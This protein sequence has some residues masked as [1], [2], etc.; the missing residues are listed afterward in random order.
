[1]Y[2]SVKMRTYRWECVATFNEKDYVQADVIE[3]SKKIYFDLDECI[4]DGN[5]ALITSNVDLPCSFGYYIYIYT[6]YPD[7]EKYDERL[8]TFECWTHDYPKKESLAAAGFIHTQKSDETQCIECKIKLRNWLSSDDPHKRHQLWTPIQC[9]YLDKTFGNLL[10]KQHT[11]LK[12]PIS[13]MEADCNLHQ[14][15]SRSE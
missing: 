6:M 7:F 14:I 1:M 11:N 2:Y 10:P 3:S 4:K 9:E 15:N 5:E 8:K 13:R 12:S